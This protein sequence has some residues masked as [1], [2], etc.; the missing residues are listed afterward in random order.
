MYVV[1]DP[2]RAQTALSLHVDW[3]SSERLVPVWVDPNAAPARA[4]R[5]DVA[6]QDY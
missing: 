1:D 3:V 5:Q 6:A 4:D 2:E